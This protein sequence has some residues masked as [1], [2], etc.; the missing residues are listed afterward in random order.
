MPSSGRTVA[1]KSGTAEA[2][3]AF[4]SCRKQ[5]TKAFF[6]LLTPNRKEDPL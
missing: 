6:F 2:Y 5:E 1:K 3:D 4:V